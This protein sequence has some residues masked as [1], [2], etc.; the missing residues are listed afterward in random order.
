MT[1]QQPEIA[2]GDTV[3]PVLDV[4]IEGKVTDGVFRIDAGVKDIALVTLHFNTSGADILDQ[5]LAVTEANWA[6][7]HEQI[8]EAVEAAMALE[9]AAP[10]EDAKHRAELAV[11]E[12][13]TIETVPTAAGEGIS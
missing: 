1:E 3:G 2:E 7:V 9:D 8:V 13:E 4:K 12:P 6:A 11:A 10:V 5:L